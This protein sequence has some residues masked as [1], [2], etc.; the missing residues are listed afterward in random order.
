[1]TLSEITPDTDSDR[2]MTPNLLMI[3]IKSK[4]IHSR[5]GIMPVEQNISLGTEN[6]P[7]EDDD[8]YPVDLKLKK[9]LKHMVGLQIP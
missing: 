3:L 2:P 6:F 9:M 8:E 7:G 1:V 4:R 5:K